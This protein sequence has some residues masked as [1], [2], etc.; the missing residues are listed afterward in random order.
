MRRHHVAYAAATLL[1]MLSA[2]A[3]GGEAASQATPPKAAATK[4]AAPKVITDKDFDRSN[5]SNPTKVDNVWFPLTPG[6]Q[7]VFE[8]S[9][10]GDEGREP[11]RVV[12]TVTDLTKVIDGVRTVVI[13][14]RDYTAGELVEAELAFFA[15]DDDGNGWHLGQYPEEYE[16]GKVVK[17]PA[18][19]AGLEGGK[20]GV[21]MRAAPRLGTSDYAQG[22]GPKVGWRDRAKVLKTGQK[23]CVPAGCYQNVLVTEEWDAADPAARQLKYYAPGVGNVKVGWAGRDEEQEVLA[24]VKVHRLDAKGLADVRAEALKLEKRAYKVSKNLYGRTPPAE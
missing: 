16:G 2:S 8:G 14:E 21:S 1:L 7:L 5:F 6:T 3:C 15:Q 23:T 22:L 24:L 11:R 20:A 12:F 10:N 17:A 4:A 18:W 13:W 9:A 19:I